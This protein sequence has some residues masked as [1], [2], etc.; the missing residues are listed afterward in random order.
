VF[1]QVGDTPARHERPSR[2]SSLKPGSCKL[3]PTY[4]FLLVDDPELGVVEPL[5]AEELEELE[6]FSPEDFSPEDPSDFPAPSPEPFLPE[7]PLFPA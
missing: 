5:S 4:S 1:H 3:S 2:A 7:P 6:D